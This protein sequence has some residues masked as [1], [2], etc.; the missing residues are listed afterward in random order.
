[1]VDDLLENLLVTG[2]FGHTHG[3][4]SSVETVATNIKR[5]GLF[6]YLQQQGEHNWKAYQNHKALKPFCWAYQIGRYVRRGLG[7]GRSGALLAAD[8]KRSGSRYDL[9]TRL[10]ID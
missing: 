6:R 7:T 5:T 1:M 10:G 8:Y 3:S 4:G 9:L 2:N